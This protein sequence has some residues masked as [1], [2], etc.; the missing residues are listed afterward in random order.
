MF[1]LRRKCEINFLCGVELL[2][3]VSN[4]VQSAF[5]RTFSNSQPRPPQTFNCPLTRALLTTATNIACWTVPSAAEFPIPRQRTIRGDT[6]TV[7]SFLWGSPDSYNT[8]NFYSGALGSGTL[9]ASISGSALTHDT[10]GSGFD[11]VTFTATGG[12]IGSVV[13][14]DAGSAAFEYAD[15]TLGTNGA[16]TPLPAALPLFAGGL[17]LVA[18]FSRRRKQNKSTGVAV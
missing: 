8:V 13:L 4:P 3:P 6:T 9:I 15:Q 10:P 7:F 1:Y 11:F 16:Q 17:G 14:E 18:L 2:L 5:F 12:T